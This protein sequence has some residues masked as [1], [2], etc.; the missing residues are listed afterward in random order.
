MEIHLLPYTNQHE[1]TSTNMVN[2]DMQDTEQ[3]M[4]KFCNIIKCL[5]IHKHLKDLKSI[6]NFQKEKYL[7]SVE[8]QKW[9][10]EEK[11]FILYSSIIFFCFF[12]TN[13]LPF[14]CY[15]PSESA[16]LWDSSLTCKLVFP[17]WL[18]CH[19]H[20]LFFLN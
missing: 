17:L 20:R 4:F 9:D 2:R 19:R 3:K 8:L 16:F 14:H 7:N 5:Y 13:T 6:G 18:S 11:F 12:T 10:R 1:G 15:T